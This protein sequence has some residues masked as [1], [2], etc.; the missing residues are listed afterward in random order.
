[1]TAVCENTGVD[2]HRDNVSYSKYNLTDCQRVPLNTIQ[3]QLSSAAILGGRSHTTRSSQR[4]ERIQ[5]YQHND[6]IYRVM[7]KE[8]S[9][10]QILR[11]IKGIPTSGKPSLHTH[12]HHTL[13][14][15]LT[16]THSLSLTHTHSSLSL[17][18]SLTHTHLR[19]KHTQ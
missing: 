14:L 7:L 18:L 5:R 16:H 3:L 9:P 15:S 13:S 8:T 19:H 10:N 17:S 12:T 4:T 1:M 6:S 11:K 2:Q